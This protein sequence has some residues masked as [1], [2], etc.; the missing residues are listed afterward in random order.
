MKTDGSK[1]VNT[2]ITI[3]VDIPILKPIGIILLVIGSI[4]FALTVTLFVI[5][6]KSKDT[7]RSV[8]YITI[9]VQQQSTDQQEV[10]HATTSKYCVN[11]GTESDSD[12]NFC[13][14]CGFAYKKQ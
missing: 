5:A 2:D 4:F 9:P 1:G 8:K 11:C 6:Y 14:T 12:A 13:E 3:G 7:P 10:S